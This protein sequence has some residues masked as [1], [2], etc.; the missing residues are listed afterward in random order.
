MLATALS[1]PV[2]FLHTG[3]SCMDRICRIL[4]TDAHALIRFRFTGVVGGG[5]VTVVPE[6][7]TMSGSDVKLVTSRHAPAPDLFLAA[8][9][10]RWSRIS[11]TEKHHGQLPRCPTQTRRAKEAVGVRK[12]ATSG[13]IETTTRGGREC[14][15]FEG[16]RRD[17]CK[18]RCSQS[19]RWCII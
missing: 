1:A 14:G 5:R 4:A 19:R 8:L 15:G 13:C 2:I 7:E 9:H 3:L 6:A 18:R 10:A 12:G 17:V 16:I 11:R